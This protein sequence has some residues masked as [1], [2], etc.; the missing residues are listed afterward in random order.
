[1]AFEISVFLKNKIAHFE[2]VTNALKRENINI[3]S[4]TLM[5][6][7]QG[8]GVVKLLVNQ[9]EK[10]YQILS[11]RGDSVSLREILALEMKDST[12]GLDELLVQVARAG[13]HMES[14]Y[15]RLISG[16]KKAVLILEV[17]DV[18]EAKLRLERKGVKLLDDET[19][20][21]R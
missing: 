3:S 11:D 13:I 2:E 21:G 6:I 7:Y 5:N 14:A 8:W 18:I 4:M 1:M 17:P 16:S 10:A 15:T 20:Y 12:G 9:P 19:V